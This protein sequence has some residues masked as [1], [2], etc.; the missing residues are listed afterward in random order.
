MVREVAKVVL[1]SSAEVVGVAISRKGVV[2]LERLYRV[3]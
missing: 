3:A 1:Q 2:L